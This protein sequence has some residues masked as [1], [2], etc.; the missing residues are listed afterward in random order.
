QVRLASDVHFEP[1]LRQEQDA[2]SRL[3][4]PGLRA[5]QDHLRPHA[6]L[7]MAGRGGGDPQAGLGAA[8]ALLRPAHPHPGRGQPDAVNRPGLPRRGRER[9]DV[10]ELMK[11]VRGREPSLQQELKGTTLARVRR[12]LT[13]REA[14]WPVAYLT[15]RS[16]FG[17]LEL[18]IGPGA[19]I[20]RESSEF[21]AE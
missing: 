21:M 18:E 14:G 6:T 2:V 12:L 15:G 9:D 17:G 10:I 13:K 8:F 5:G 1:G 4:V 20:P 11:F 7:R 19:F 3:Q 16:Q